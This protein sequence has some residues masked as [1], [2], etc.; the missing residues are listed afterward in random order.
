MKIKDQAN[1][2]TKQAPV[3]FGPEHTVREALDVMCVKNIGSII[4]VNDDETIAGILTERDLMIRVLGPGKDP[5]TTPVSEIMTKDVRVAREDDDVMDWM[6]VMSQERFRR[7]PVVDAEGKLVNILSQGDFVAYSWADL[8]EQTKENL[9]SR[10]KLLFPILFGILG[11]L[12]LILIT[13]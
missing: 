1:Y 12:T 10:Y 6:S 13:G 5:D 3:T 11:I 2:K 4:V 9:K 7:L 8:L